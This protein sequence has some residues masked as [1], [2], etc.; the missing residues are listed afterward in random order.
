MFVDYGKK[1][2]WL[3]AAFRGRASI[4]QP[5]YNRWRAADTWRNGPW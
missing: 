5:K 2:Q 4:R 1:M 3:N